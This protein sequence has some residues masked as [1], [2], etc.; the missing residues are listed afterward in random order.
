MGRAADVAD[1]AGAHEIGQ[2][3]Q[4]LVDRDVRTGPVDLVEVDVVGAEAPQRR[5]ARAQDV[6]ARVALIVRAETGPPVDLGAEDHL[7][8]AAGQ[9]LADDALRIAR[10]VDVGG[11]D[12]V[13][14]RVQRGVDDPDR[15][16]LVRASAEVHRAEAQRRH[17]HAGPAQQS[18]VHGVLHVRP[19]SDSPDSMRRMRISPR[20]PTWRS[21]APAR[22]SSPRPARHAGGCRPR[23]SRCPFRS[24]RGERAPP[25]RWALP[26]R[27]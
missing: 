26:T 9:R 8:A 19:G 11:I 4:R 12:E 13:D 25:S 2:R 18:M 7:V 15:V 16:G 10:V 27:R 1:L 23:S 20:S 17:A 24:S 21:S 5:V 14:A 22:R 3:A 6:Q